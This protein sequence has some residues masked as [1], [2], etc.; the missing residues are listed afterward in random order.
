MATSNV[1]GEW[2]VINWSK[3][4]ADEQ[5]LKADLR[6]FNEEIKEMNHAKLEAIICLNEAANYQDKEW[7]DCRIAST[8][9]NSAGILGGVLTIGGGIATIF[10]AG[11][12]TPLLMAGF[13]LGLAAAGTGL[14]MDGN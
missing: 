10:T 8:I 11:A 5:Q 2:Q 9:G 12:A 13:S 4:A 7:R 14:R 1:N 3:F 6:A